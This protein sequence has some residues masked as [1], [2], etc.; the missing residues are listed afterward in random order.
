MM[1]LKKRQKIREKHY[2][3]LDYAI[4]KNNS[5]MCIVSAFMM[6]IK[7]IGKF[8]SLHRP[9]SVT[10]LITDGWARKIEFFTGI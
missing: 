6:S 1:V 4:P 5:R 10:L 3:K 2:G 8:S 9:L 7:D